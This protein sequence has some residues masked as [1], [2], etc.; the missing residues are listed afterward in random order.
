MFLP[1]RGQGRLKLIAFAGSP[2]QLPQLCKGVCN[3]GQRAKYL[4]RAP[5]PWWKPR[6]IQ[7]QRSFSGG[8]RLAPRE[9][10]L[11]VAK[12]RLCF[13]ERYKVPSHLGSKVTNDSSKILGKMWREAETFMLE[14]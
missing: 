3:E 7:T 12:T 10:D 8:A 11:S 4:A 14:F 13:S 6:G 2:A 9:E 1:I 5:S